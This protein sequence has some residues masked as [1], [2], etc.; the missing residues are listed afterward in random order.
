MNKVADNKRLVPILSRFV[1]RCLRRRAGGLAGSRVLAALTAAAIL[2]GVQ[3]AARFERADTAETVLVTS[4]AAPIPALHSVPSYRITSAPRTASRLP[5]HIAAALP[6][7]AHDGLRRS[8]TLR[9]STTG[10][11]EQPVASIVS[12]GYDATA[13]PALS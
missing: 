11:I 8:F 10:A 3:T 2:V 12:R 5:D 1:S 13:P 9:A 7:R 6:A 4:L